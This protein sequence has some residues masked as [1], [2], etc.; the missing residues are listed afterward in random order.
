MNH[1]EFVEVEKLQFQIAEQWVEMILPVKVQ[2]ESL[3]PS[4]IP[5]KA[6]APEDEKMMCSLL[7]VQEEEVICGASRQLMD[8]DGVLGHR[9]RLMEME[10]GYA[11]ELQ[12][13]EGGEWSRMTCDSCF[14]VGMVYMNMKDSCAG[15][16]LSSFM[17]MMFAQASVLRRT[18]LIHAS[19]VQKDGT[20]Y[21][22]L[23]KSGTGKSTHSMMWMRNLEGLSLLN[24][25]NPA[26]RIAGDGEV[27]VY[28][29]PWSG[30]TPCYKNE[31]ARLQALVR[32]EQ[33]PENNFY[34]EWGI[35]AI[36]ALL[37]GCSSMRW[38]NKLYMALVDMLEVIVHTVPVGHLKC[39]PNASAALLCYNEITK[40][41]KN[42]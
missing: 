35:A 1:K 23:G 2:M 6:V 36:L 20:G 3:L 31:K 13:V 42:K 39:L 22:F 26:I 30:K 41:I 7:V 33:A 25:D 14:S 19:V 18:V 38:N 4:F 8:V 29:T 28:G 32:L 11:V 12:M 34:R 17:M 5:F 24:D 27:Y 15:Q 16:I 37:P 9:F 40:L 21:A 10:K